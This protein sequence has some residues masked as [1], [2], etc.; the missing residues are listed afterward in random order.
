MKTKLL[1]LAFK[2]IAVLFTLLAIPFTAHGQNLYVSVNGP[3]VNGAGSIAEY[4]PA[5]IQTTF[6]GLDA[7]R[8]MDFDSS[9]NFLVATTRTTPS[10]VDHGRVSNFPP[11]GHATVVGNAAH[12]FLQG[13][14]TDRAGNVFVAAVN[15]FS[16]TLA[17]T[18]YKFAPDGTR[19]VFGSTPGQTFALAFDSAGNPFAADALDIKIYKFAPGGT[20][21]VFAG[22]GAFAS[23]QAPVGLAFDSA[24]NLFVSTEGDPGNDDI[25]E[26]TPS[27]MENTFAGGLTQPRGLAF[28]GSGNL[29]VAEALESPDGDVLEFPAAGGSV[30]FASGLD[31]PE[32]LTFGPAR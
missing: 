22:P 4:T 1:S 9:G 14:V 17:S 8:G 28:D 25:L 21:S 27:G 24:G 30:V 3:F 23:N 19:T 16:P 32:Y 31:R 18:I 10:F 11:A 13:V 20:R 12:S 29:F 15:D 2:H 7:P 26:F 5:G 6:A